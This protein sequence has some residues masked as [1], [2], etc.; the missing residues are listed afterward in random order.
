MTKKIFLSIIT[1]SFLAVTAAIFLLTGVSYRYAADTS[2]EHLRQSCTMIASA[3]EQSGGRYLDE[4]DFG[5]LRVTWISAKGRVIF[6]SQH[7]PVQ[8]D[9]HSDR[10]EVGEAMRSGEGSSA[11]YSDTLMTRTVNHAR[12]LSDGSVI[13]VSAEQ[14]SFPALLLKNLQPL[15]VMLTALAL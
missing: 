7:D 1:V 10:Q 15:A 4:T 13:R 3:V 12:R 5:E 2:A 8:L 9:D 14:R 11:R 6:D